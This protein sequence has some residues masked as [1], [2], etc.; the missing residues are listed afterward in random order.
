VAHH[1]ITVF[2]GYRIALGVVL[3]VLLLTGVVAAT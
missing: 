1:P 2:I 3:A